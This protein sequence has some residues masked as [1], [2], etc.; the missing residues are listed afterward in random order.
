MS[1][2]HA[3]FV[4]LGPKCKKDGESP[5]YDLPVGAKRCPVCSSKRVQRL[6]NAVNI[7]KPG[8]YEI[9]RVVDKEGARRLEEHHDQRDAAIR[10]QKSG[11]S[12]FAVDPKN[13]GG[14]I[15]QAVSR[16]R[17]HP[18]FNSMSGL[19]VAPGPGADGV[20]RREIMGRM[21][22]TVVAARDEQKIVKRADGQVEIAK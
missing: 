17:L 19:G 9:N 8:F 18:A 5:V 12:T 6:Y 4:C 7:S 21:A 22:D 1:G 20:P 15:A 10:A 16:G 2:P 3:D 13:I 14:G 11:T